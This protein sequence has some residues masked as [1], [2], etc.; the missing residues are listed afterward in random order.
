MI[1]NERVT[2][3]TYNKILPV[4]VDNISTSSVLAARLFSNPTSWAGTVLNSPSMFQ[5]STTGGSF[6][7]MDTFLSSA[8]NVTKSFSWY[9]KGIYQSIVLPGIEQSVNA[10]TE[11]QAINL[12]GV[13][14]AEAFAALASNLGNQ[15]YGVGT[16]KDVE[17]LELIVD[18]GTNSSSYGGITRS[19]NTWINADVN[20]ASGGA[21][22]LD[23]LFSEFDAASASGADSEN[24]TM[25]LTTK[26][27]WTLI[28]SLLTPNI[29]AQYLSTSSIAG[30]DRV[31]KST[32]MGSTVQAQDNA[33]N[34]Q[35]GFRAYNLRG[36]PV[37]PDD[38]CTSGV[39]YWINENYLKAKSLKG[40][41]LTAIPA[42][43][44]VM[45]GV[46]DSFPKLSAFQYRDVMAVPL[47][48]GKVGQLI[49]LGN[50]VD[51]QPRRNSK[52]TAITT[53]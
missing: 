15:V 52:L 31:G 1:F 45:D 7:G 43:G 48:Y 36:T 13:R 25:G 38:K 50:V 44:N 53:A 16:G 12:V 3:I 11:S 28:E 4:V 40:V 30:Y 34:G 17:G 35:Q 27:V 19:T 5:L 37:V 9:I 39:F 2:D 10:V 21:V 46:N 8:Q 32:P 49:F 33:L 26:T 18:A 41:D 14:S 22:T 51:V 42:V 24:P 29:V 23:N 6:D 20:A 47:Q